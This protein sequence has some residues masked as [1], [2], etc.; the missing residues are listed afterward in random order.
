[1]VAAFKRFFVP[2]VSIGTPNGIITNLD[3]SGVRIEW[4]IVR[5]NTNRPDQGQITVYNLSPT[6]TAVLFETWQAVSRGVGYTITF[7]IGW[8]RVPQVVFVGDVWELIP[9]QRTPS[10]VLTIFKLGDGNK[11]LRDQAVGRSFSNVKIDIVLDWLVSLPPA[12]TDAGGGGLGLIYPPESKAVVAAASAELP[13]QTWGNIPAYANTR[14]AINIIM[15]TL[16]LEWRVH[17]NQFIVMRGGVINRP[18]P[19]LIRPGTGLISYEKRNDGGIQFEAL[20][21]PEVEPGIQLFVQ[22]DFGKPFGEPVYRCESV[23]FRGST[24]EDSLMAVEGAKT[25]LV[26]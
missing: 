12:P 20:A 5:D 1:M 18:N 3:S 25:V 24:D 17:N 8:D 26:G 10:D 22:D 7:S 2:A 11:T 21:N 15:D 19:P 9:D 6:F 4:E 14:D 23:A 13:V 16:G